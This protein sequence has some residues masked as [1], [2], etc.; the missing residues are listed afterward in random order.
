MRG[1]LSFLGPTPVL[2]KGV[3][4]GLSPALSGSHQKQLFQTPLSSS[5]QMGPPILHL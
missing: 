4:V 5:S 3:S 2:H 1:V